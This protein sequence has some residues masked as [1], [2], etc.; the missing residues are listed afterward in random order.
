MKS[1]P[2]VVPILVVALA[3]CF[4]NRPA[5]RAELVD[6][7]SESTPVAP[8]PEQ[9]RIAFT[10]DDLP[11]SRDGT[12]GLQRM[13]EVTVRLLAQLKRAGIHAVG[14]VNEAKLG[15]GGDP[16]ARIA[17]LE[18]WLDAGMELG[19]HTYAHLKFWDTPLEQYERDV[20]RG[21]RVIRPLLAE[22]GQRPRYFRHPY[23]STGPTAEAK[24]AFERF[25]SEHGYTIAPVTIDNMDVMYALA[26]D[27][28]L[29]A[30]GEVPQRRIA[31]AYVDHMRESVEYFER[32]SHDILGREPAQVLMLHAN[33]LNADHLHELVAMLQQRG[34]AF[35]PLERALRDSAYALPDTYIGP[36][37][38]SWLQRWAVSRGSDPGKEPCA[39]GWIQRAAYP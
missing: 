5:R 28:S 8:Q 37:G 13:E 11:M 38:P 9:R 23:L 16:G 35:I 12:Y 36:T 27:N 21:E 29:E 34:Y 26:Y 30:G 22:R 14:F 24:A 7:V 18:Q 3:G 33:A 6:R 17:L 10:F 31:A 4:A 19:N 1:I 2:R 20:L 32:L 15:R 25:L 39:P